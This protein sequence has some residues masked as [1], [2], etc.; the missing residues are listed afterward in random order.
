MDP[1][2]NLDGGA[3]IAYVSRLLKEPL[4]K[5]HG[6]RKLRRRLMSVLGRNGRFRIRLLQPLVMYSGVILHE[7]GEREIFYPEL[8][9][10]KQRNLVRGTLH[11]N[12]VHL[13]VVVPSELTDSEIQRLTKAIRG[14][15]GL[16]SPD[17]LA[18]V[19]PDSPKQ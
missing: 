1:Q 10:T 7:W 15:D 11:G 13:S 5:A 16:T 17:Y 3:R 9:V 19:N 2:N 18:V 14:S 6:T 12:N 8:L 4:G